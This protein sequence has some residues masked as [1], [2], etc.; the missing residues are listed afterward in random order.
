MRTSRKGFTLV[1]LLAVISVF[2][3]S[4]ATIVL[5]LYGLRQSSERVQA[6]LQAGVQQ[7]RFVHQLRLDAHDAIAP[8]APPTANTVLQLVLPE[9]Q[10]IEYSLHADRIERLVRSGDTVLQRESY[11]VTPDV[12]QGWTTV[13]TG[14]RPLV[15]VYL[16]RPAI[17]R[18][19]VHPNALPWRIEAAVG[20]LSS[21]N[22]KPSAESTP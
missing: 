7:T 20:L 13:T 15:A 17:G 8:V 14:A 6:H 2:T 10:Q 1:E 19:Q 11:R 12:Q 18:S 16:Q 5:T 22:S 4:L 3:V 9:D 21:D